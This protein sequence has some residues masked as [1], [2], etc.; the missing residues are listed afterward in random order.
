MRLIEILKAF[1]PG[2]E[3]RHEDTPVTHYGMTIINHE[4]LVEFL[5]S[6]SQ[7]ELLSDGWRVLLPEDAF[8]RTHLPPEG[9]GHQSRCKAVPVINAAEPEKLPFRSEHLLAV[10]RRELDIPDRRDV[11]VRELWLAMQLL[12]TPENCADFIRRSLVVT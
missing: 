3:V 10:L 6:R 1:K 5:A 9:F 8:W 11:I 2:M 4:G 7:E 12:A